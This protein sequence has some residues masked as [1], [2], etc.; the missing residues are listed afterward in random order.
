MK[1]KNLAVLIILLVIGLLFGSLLGELFANSLPFLSKSQ[2]I[3]WEPKADLNILKYDFFIQV[4][5][6]LASVIG[7]I[8]AFWIYKKI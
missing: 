7:L 6:N 5:I 1:N 3:I 4:K 8:I 2:Q